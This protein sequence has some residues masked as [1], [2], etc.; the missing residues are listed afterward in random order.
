MGS[1]DYS[2]IYNK[3][4]FSNYFPCFGKN[5]IFLVEF[6]LLNTFVRVFCR[7]ARISCQEFYWNFVYVI[8][9]N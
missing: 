9:N 5:I 8:N 6:P 3:I 1:K 2:E 7:E 4:E